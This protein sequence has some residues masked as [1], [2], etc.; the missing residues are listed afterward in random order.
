MVK[1]IQLILSFKIIIQSFKKEM[2]HFIPELSEKRQQDKT[3]GVAIKKLYSQLS[4]ILK[5]M[6]HEK[7]GFL[8]M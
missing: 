5:E 4:N 6:C 3:C 1:E 7:T 2:K 8:H